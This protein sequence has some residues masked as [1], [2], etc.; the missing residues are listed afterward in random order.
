MLRSFEIIN[1]ISLIDV[2]GILFITMISI[3]EI[4]AQTRTTNDMPIVLVTDLESDQLAMIEPL[5]NFLQRTEE[6]IVEAFPKHEFYKGLLK[7]KY[8]LREDH[9]VLPIKGTIITV[10][11]EQRIFPNKGFLSKVQLNSGD[12]YRL[13]AANAKVISN[14]KGEL[15]LRIQ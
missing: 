13:G 2:M 12:D 6:D 11:T 10:Y 1:R 14:Q 4:K 9:L 3:V 8:E 7:G 15:I 5:N